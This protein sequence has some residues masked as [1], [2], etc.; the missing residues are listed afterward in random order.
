MKLFKIGYALTGFLLAAC[1]AFTGSYGLS[2][3]DRE[4]YRRALSLENDMEKMGFSEFSL[5]DYKV[6]FC[7]GNCDYV[8]EGEKPLVFTGNYLFPQVMGQVFF[9]P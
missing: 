9:Y 8:V 3:T 7:N 4:I 6:R 5:A 1:T 2:K